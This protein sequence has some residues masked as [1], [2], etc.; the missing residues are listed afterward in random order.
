MTIVRF[1]LRSFRSLNE[2]WSDISTKNTFPHHPQANTAPSKLDEDQVWIMFRKD[3]K[4]REISVTLSTRAKATGSQPKLYQI[5]TRM[6][7]ARVVRDLM[8]PLEDRCF[9]SE[10][11]VM[12]RKS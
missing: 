5:F 1:I 4:L 11:R 7:E 12:A 10:L 8:E 3:N 9:R 6:R 2:F